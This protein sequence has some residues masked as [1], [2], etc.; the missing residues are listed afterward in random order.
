MY[1]GMVAP[2][3][4]VA[5]KPKNLGEVLGIEGGGVEKDRFSFGES[6]RRT[7]GYIDTTDI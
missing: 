7:I 4:D 1:G 2:A 5:K 6:L 3:G